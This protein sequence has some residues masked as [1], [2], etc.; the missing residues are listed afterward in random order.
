MKTFISNSTSED[1][2]ILSNNSCKLLSIIDKIICLIEHRDVLVE[3]TLDHFVYNLK[4]SYRKN[5]NIEL[6]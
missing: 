2:E 4:E 5:L 1:K 6:R 3:T